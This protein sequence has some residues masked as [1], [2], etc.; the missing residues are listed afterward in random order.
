M[1]TFKARTAKTEQDRGES[2]GGG[3]RL[4]LQHEAK[5]SQEAKDVELSQRVSL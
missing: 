3:R 1:P 5:Q 4:P 2:G